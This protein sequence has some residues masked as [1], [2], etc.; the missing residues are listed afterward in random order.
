VPKSRAPGFGLSFSDLSYSGVR[1]RLPILAGLAV[2]VVAGL[3]ARGGFRPRPP[4]PVYYGWPLSVWLNKLEN[5]ELTGINSG[6]AAREHDVMRQMG[7]NCLPTLVRMLGQKDTA[8]KL[9]LL[10]LARKQS[11]IKFRYHQAVLKNLVAAQWLE[12][13]GPE[14]QPA[15]PGLISLYAAE[16]SP[17]SQG[18]IAE[19]FGA[20]GP[21]AAAAVPCLLLGASSTNSYLRGVSVT[22]LG[23]IHADPNKVVPALVNALQDPEPNVRMSAADSLGEFGPEARSA[24]PALLRLLTDQD[25][26]EEAADS[27]LKIAPKASPPP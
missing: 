19:V 6:K 22:A 20:I 11:L 17:Y 1:K 18:R 7:T 3:S 23:Q 21:S 24:A 10:A 2:I 27:L 12:T 14:A 25:A 5:C 15:L 13:L 16:T 26:N 4:E 8:L 9:K